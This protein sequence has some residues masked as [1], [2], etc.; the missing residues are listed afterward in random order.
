[1]FQAI[2]QTTLVTANLDQFF[3]FTTFFVA[4]VGV[5]LVPLGGVRLAVAVDVLPDAN[6]GQ[7]AALEWHWF[8]A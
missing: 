4:S 3:S 8:I 1:M 2:R 5:D 7:L 6:V